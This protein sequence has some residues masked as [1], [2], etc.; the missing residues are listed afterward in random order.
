MSTT[1]I[2]V[3]SCSTISPWVLQPR[4]AGYLVRHIPDDSHRR[5]TWF[6]RRYSDIR[7]VCMAVKYLEM[8]YWFRNT[9]SSNK[10]TDSL[11]CRCRRANHAAAALRSWLCGT[12]LWWTGELD[13]WLKHLQ[14]CF[15]TAFV[16]SSYESYYL[17]HTMGS[18]VAVIG[19]ATQSYAGTTEILVI[20]W[21]TSPAKS[22]L[23]SGP[24]GPM[25]ILSRVGCMPR[26]K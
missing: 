5:D 19:D 22:F 11:C 14:G 25:N 20:Y 2:R 10:E 12:A 7:F 6:Q 17:Q 8:I 24:G 16:T 26:D 18:K 15:V 3:K 23:I 4:N 13:L 9:A 21:W 1:R